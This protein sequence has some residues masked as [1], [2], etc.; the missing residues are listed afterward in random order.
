VRLRTALTIG[1]LTSGAIFDGNA[2]A[3][4]VG[5][6]EVAPAG[7]IVQLRVKVFETDIPPQHLWEPTL[8][9]P[10]GRTEAPLK[11][12]RCGSR[13]AQVGLTA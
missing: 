13:A 11:V 6:P 9:S 8:G 12:F 4:F 2:A 10:N 3:V 7:L 1:S 5:L